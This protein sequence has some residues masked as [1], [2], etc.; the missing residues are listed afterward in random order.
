MVSDIEILRMH[1][2]ETL[3]HWRRRFGANRDAIA[4]LYDERFCRMFEFYLAGSELAFRRCGH[5]IWQMQLAHRHDVVPLT[6]DY[7]AA[8][9]AG[10]LVTHTAEPVSLLRR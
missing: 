2:A 1:Y 3:R 4:A 7:I 9:E 8:V 5:M 10:R 6:R